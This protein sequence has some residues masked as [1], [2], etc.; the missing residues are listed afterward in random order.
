MSTPEERAL[1]FVDRVRAVLGYEFEL[2]TVHALWLTAER[3]TMVITGLDEGGLKI[4]FGLT[5]QP[6][7]IE[8]DVFYDK[9]MAKLPPPQGQRY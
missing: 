5:T 4:Q 6:D 9:I 7:V 1:I 8:T 2:I 3:V